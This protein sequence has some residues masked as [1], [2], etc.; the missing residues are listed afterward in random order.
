MKDAQQVRDHWEEVADNW[1]D[2]C[3]EGLWRRHADAVNGG[4]FERWLPAAPVECLLKTDLFDE[5]AS[6]GLAETLARRCRVLIGMDISGGTT[7]AAR[8]R[9]RAMAITR[10]D[11]RALPF[12]TG[13]FDAI[14][15]NSTLDHFPRPE[16]VERS[17]R[18][19]HRILRP[20]GE[21][22]IT[23]D[24]L[25][26]PIVALRNALPFSW[27]RRLRIMPFFVGASC[28]P[29]GL[30]RLLEATGFEIREMGAIL[31]CPRF[32]SIHATMFLER[33]ASPA[34]QERFL[35][36]LAGFEQLGRWPTRYLT[37]C[38]VTARAVRKPPE[39]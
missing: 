14:A 19:L 28:G 32:L 16:D 31:H 30:R 38:F 27:L 22:M 6:G 3:P 36:W 21:L 39:V 11:A 29:R 13:S 4:L 35:R 24:N 25:A 7:R 1:R 20:G 37:G 2:R 18:E 12:A 33:H 34:T 10:A 26:H 15:S 17:L 23:M 5:A 9:V 8:R